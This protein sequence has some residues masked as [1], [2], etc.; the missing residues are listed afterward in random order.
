MKRYLIFTIFLCASAAAPV[1]SEAEGRETSLAQSD[2]EGRSYSSTE[3]AERY[4]ARDFK[5]VPYRFFEPLGF[6]NDDTRK[7]PLVLSLH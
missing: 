4:E 3:L 2:L 6:K 1:L 5:G 7:Y